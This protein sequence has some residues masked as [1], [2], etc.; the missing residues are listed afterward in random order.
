MGGVFFHHLQQCATALNKRLD[1]VQFLDESTSQKALLAISWQLGSA[2]PAT[3]E[4]ALQALRAFCTC[5]LAERW[6]WKADDGSDLSNLQPSKLTRNRNKSTDLPI[7]PMSDFSQNV[8]EVFSR[9][10]VYI[11]YKLVQGDWLKKSQRSKIHTIR[12]LTRIISLLRTADLGKFLP[13]IMFAIESSLSHPAAQVQ[14]AGAQLV[15]EVASRLPVPVLVDNAALLIVGFY[16]L[17][18]MDAGKST[19]TDEKASFL[20]HLVLNDLPMDRLREGAVDP[21]EKVVATRKQDRM[22]LSEETTCDPA[23]VGISVDDICSIHLPN[24]TASTICFRQQA[25][26]VAV[27]TLNK[28]FVEMGNSLHGALKS[29]PFFPPLPAL[30]EVQRLHSIQQQTLSHEEKFHQLCRMLAHDSAHLR[31]L[32]LRQIFVL[33]LKRRKDLHA[34]LS[35][36]SSSGKGVISET[37]CLQHVLSS[38]VMLGS[39]DSDP[40]I[41][42]MVGK[43]LGEIGAVDPARVS[44]LPQG[45]QSSTSIKI[46]D[47][48][49]LLLHPKFQSVWSFGLI[50][51]EYEL[52]PELRGDIDNVFAQ[53]RTCFAI[54]TVLRVLALTVPDF[55]A[56]C[57]NLSLGEAQ[58]GGRSPR[59]SGASGI[60]PTL[61]LMPSQLHTELQN[62]Q[63]LGKTLKWFSLQYL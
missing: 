41:R 26:S 32:A 16:P 33:L 36:A 19:L 45:G 17:L 24:L 28:M 11:F 22:F 35:I 15:H 12:A 48:T 37:C 61:P 27:R 1:P 55:A 21:V 43:C 18:E 3:S 50:L 62:K 9:L 40:K 42:E 4:N 59:S 13:K 51:L 23:L 8:S 39:R 58:A 30:Q 52:V 34:D 7:F 2:T 54:Q 44:F 47:S 31:L 10:F 25:Q 57:K 29:I 63:L 60:S 5:F 20:Q 6:A 14:L 56:Q 46:G 49:H 38:L 53:D